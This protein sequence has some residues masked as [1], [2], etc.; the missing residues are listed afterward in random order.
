[1]S[2]RRTRSFCRVSEYLGS[3]SHQRMLCRCQIVAMLQLESPWWF[4]PAAVKK[5]STAVSELRSRS[6][7]CLMRHKARQTPDTLAY[8]TRHAGSVRVLGQPLAMRRGQRRGNDAFACCALAL[9][10]WSPLCAGY[11]RSP[12]SPSRCLVHSRRQCS[13]GGSGCP[14]SS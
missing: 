10:S 9:R 11:R 12:Q 7:G 14:S 6:Y 4:D 5:G 13:P 3:G 2:L 8:W 1:M